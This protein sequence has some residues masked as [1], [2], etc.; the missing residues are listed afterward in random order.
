MQT[1]STL[2]T[3]AILTIGQT[4]LLHQVPWQRDIF[5]LFS[6]PLDMNT[7]ENYGRA[8]S[9]QLLAIPFSV[10]GHKSQLLF[11]HLSCK[12]A[13]YFSSHPATCKSTICK[14]ACMAHI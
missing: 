1:N 9:H 13:N 10:V 14:C 8:G 11:L 3:R 2:Q 7:V 5:P 4:M 12:A 6:H